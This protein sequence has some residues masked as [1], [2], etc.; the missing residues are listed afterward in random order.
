MLKYIHAVFNYAFPN[1]EANLSD[2][3][4]RFF[5]FSHFLKLS[6]SYSVNTKELDRLKDFIS[7]AREKIEE[8]QANSLSELTCRYNALIFL[9]RTQEFLD[10]LKRPAALFALTFINKKEKIKYFLEPLINISA[11][12]GGNDIQSDLY[13]NRCMQFFSDLFL[14]SKTRKNKNFFA[15]VDGGN[16][17]DLVVKK[18]SQS[19]KAFIRLLAVPMNDSEKDHYHFYLDKVVD[20][21]FA[22]KAA[23]DASSRHLKLNHEESPG[24]R[25]NLDQAR[26][27]YTKAIEELRLHS[28]KIGGHDTPVD[29]FKYFLSKFIE[30]FS[31]DNKTEKLKH[32]IKIIFKNR[33]DQVGHCNRLLSNFIELSSEKVTST[34]LKKIPENINEWLDYV[35]MALYCL[36]KRDGIQS[37]AQQFFILFKKV[38]MDLPGN[39]QDINAESFFSKEV[40]A[41]IKLNMQSHPL[42]YGKRAVDLENI[43]NQ[44][45]STIFLSEINERTTISDSYRFVG[46]ALIGPVRNLVDI[47]NMV[48]D[49]K[50]Y[51]ENIEN[52]VYN[53]LS[54]EKIQN[55]AKIF[56]AELKKHSGWFAWIF[57]GWNWALNSIKKLFKFKIEESIESQLENLAAKL[58]NGVYDNRQADFVKELERFIFKKSKLISPSLLNIVENIYTV[59]LSNIDSDVYVRE[60]KKDIKVSSWISVPANVLAIYSAINESCK[61]IASPLL[62]VTEKDERFQE[63]IKKILDSYTLT[64]LYNLTMNK[65]DFI[66][67]LYDIF[68]DFSEKNERET[69]Y[70][71]LNKITKKPDLAY[72]FKLAKETIEKT[73]SSTI[74]I[75][76]IHELIPII[77]LLGELK[78]KEAIALIANINN[79][80][81]YVLAFNKASFEIYKSL[82]KEDREEASKISFLALYYIYRG[83]ED[84]SY[85]GSGVIMDQG[86]N[87]LAPNSRSRNSLSS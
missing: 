69:F 9:K 48:L 86:V 47:I 10:E 37:I 35:Y 44:S 49:K 57:Y 52:N 41:F 39:E 60:N 84:D 7:T 53:T 11:V 17:P 16:N 56:S 2:P 20:A 82:I 30:Q 13:K 32:T 73:N 58:G 33:I 1:I 77:T 36:K 29:N 26:E 42:E 67:N 24:L 72:W 68:F 64:K 87:D 8:I 71:E 15:T 23:M 22:E 38:L 63:N 31:S 28:I 14:Y 83:S 54:S 25:G 59:V 18:L 46:E 61:N 55:I 80:L 78:D 75:Y 45:G 3:L 40:E 81:E 19:S 65:K 51:N 74:R 43:R 27:R 66:E 50:D 12:A 79:L 62:V 70:L 85:R 6:F 4:Y 34:K 21:Y 5:Y 76:V